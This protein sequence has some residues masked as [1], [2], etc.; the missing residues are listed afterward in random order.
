MPAAITQAQLNALKTT[1]VARFNKGLAITNNEWQLIA[2]LIKSDGKSNTYAWL[3]QFPA[4]REWV[5]S[6]LHKVAK[7]TAYV[8]LNR[9]FETT[10]DILRDDIEDNQLGHYG[11]VAESQGQAVSDLMNDLV[12]AKFATGFTEVCY[13]GQFFFDTDHPVYPNEDGTGVAAT[14]SN[15]QAGANAPWI[16][17][18]TKRAPQPVYLQERIKPAFESLTDA[19]SSDAVFNYDMFSFGARWRGDAAFGFWQLAFGSKADLTP[20]NFDTAYNSML[21]R[22]GDGNRR[23]GIKADTLLV[24]PTNRAAAEQLLLTE[25]LANGASNTN[26]K[27]VELIVTPWLD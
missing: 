24:G 25:K 13:D 15:M 18:C 8:V 6:R 27:R 14:V 2:K 12:F 4:F 16:L 1:L 22:K 9:K 7:E 23:L 11:D 3:S 5:G 10:L 17:L 19:N 20:A 26:Y 21:T